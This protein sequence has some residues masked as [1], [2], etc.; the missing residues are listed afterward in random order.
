[1]RAFRYVLF[2]GPIDNTPFGKVVSSIDLNVFVGKL[3][4]AF[5]KLP[6]KINITPTT[7]LGINDS[8]INFSNQPLHICLF[9]QK[10]SN[11]Q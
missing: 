2:C 9:I 11:L 8:L 1:M 6:C 3:L 4:N 10:G 7:R 5:M